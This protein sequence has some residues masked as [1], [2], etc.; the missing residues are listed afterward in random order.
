MPHAREHQIL[1]AAERYGVT[2]TPVHLCMMHNAMNR[3]SKKP[4]RYRDGLAIYWGRAKRQGSY[5]RIFWRGYIFDV[6]AVRGR[7]W[8]WRIATFLPPETLTDRFW[9][10]DKSG[11]FRP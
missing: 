2:L 1:R 6:I 10:A 7:K 9:L 3:T 4:C 11:N 8:R 5:W